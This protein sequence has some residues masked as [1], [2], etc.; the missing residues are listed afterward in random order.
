MVQTY[1]PCGVDEHVAAALVDVV[2]GRFLRAPPLAQ[3]VQVGEPGR[4]PPDIPPRRLQHA[5][6]L[7]ELAPGIDE[8]RPVQ[9]GLG[10]VLAGEDIVLEGDHRHPHIT[11]PEF[12]LRLAQLREMPPAGES[13]EVAMEDQQQP[14]AAKVRQQ[15]LSAAAV[16]ELKGEGGFAGELAHR[17]G[18][19]GEGVL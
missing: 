17:V 14:V 11:P 7:I 8:Q 2:R 1:D 13:T 9:A 10:H 6:A 5:V 19:C 12:V 15:M 18:S 4:T 16:L 3:L